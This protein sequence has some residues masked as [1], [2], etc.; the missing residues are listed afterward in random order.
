[1]GVGIELVAIEGRVVVELFVVSVD[2]EGLEFG[3]VVGLARGVGGFCAEGVGA[4]GGKV[5]A[6]VV[7][8][9]RPRKKFVEGR[10]LHVW[11]VE[12]VGGDVEEGV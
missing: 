6:E 5:G 8:L 3:E 11:E 4:E 9:S 2:A 7:V 10:I 1:M 12:E